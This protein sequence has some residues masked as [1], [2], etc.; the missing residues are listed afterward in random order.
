LL[1]ILVEDGFGVADDSLPHPHGVDLAG[2]TL[3]HQRGLAYAKSPG[4]LGLVERRV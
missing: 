3:S 1:S 2:D 4:R